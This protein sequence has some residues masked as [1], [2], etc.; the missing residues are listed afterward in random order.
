MNLSEKICIIKGAILIIEDWW[1][2]IKFKKSIKKRKKNSTKKKIYQND[3]FSEFNSIIN[4]LNE[5]NNNSNK[6]EKFTNLK[7]NKIRKS[8]KLIKNNS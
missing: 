3:T 6:K 5:S 8:N 1:K 7:Y 2:K 4:F